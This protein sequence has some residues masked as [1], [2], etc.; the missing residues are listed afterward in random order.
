MMPVEGESNAA[1][2]SSAGSSVRA[3]AIGR[4]ARRDAAE[5]PALCLAAGDDQLAAAPVR[6]AAL[7]AIGVEHLAAGDAEPGLERARR[8]IDA[9]MDH[10]AV[11]RADARA[12]RALGFE[13]QHFAALRG[14]FARHGEADDAGADDGAIDFFHGDSVAE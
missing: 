13:Q 9:G 11:A 3:A 4:G 7:G 5:L 8:V 6:D 2:H 1:V 12:E 14:E 10:L